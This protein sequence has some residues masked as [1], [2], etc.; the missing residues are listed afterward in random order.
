[1]GIYVRSTN[2]T[3]CPNV[4]IADVE[5][6]D[7]HKR[8][9]VA[10]AA[11]AGYPLGVAVRDCYIHDTD[12]IGI[13][14][15]RIDRISVLDNRLDAC[16]DTD[17]VECIWVSGDGVT[18]YNHNI[19]I[20]G[21]EIS[22]GGWSGVIVGWADH[23]TIAD[24][25]IRDCV[26]AGND[27]W[28]INITAYGSDFSITGNLCDGCGDGGIAVDLLRAGVDTTMHIARGTIT[29]NVCMNGLSNHGIYIARAQAL[30][31][32]GNTC[33]GNAFSG[34]S[35]N[36]SLRC[37]AIGNQVIN[38]GV[39][40]ISIYDGGTIANL[41]DHY[42]C[43]NVYQGNITGAYIDAQADIPSRNEDFAREV[44]TQS[45]NYTM[46]L[47]DETCIASGVGT[48]ITLLENAPV[49]KTYIVKRVDAANNIVVSREIADTID[50]AVSWSLNT[51]YAFVTCVSDGANYYII[52]Q[53]GTV[54]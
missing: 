43:G 52:A 8:G 28:G 34:I 16:G 48:T 17:D 45:S 44:T 50:G 40:G 51:D 25:N 20:R 9:V 29:G 31:I 42:L 7:S 6:K 47:M 5:I 54:V 3:G 26:K 10:Y 11:D 30:T 37:N 23:I 32:C 19:L 36:N 18:V 38:N 27:G 49:G 21:N 41:G 35:I 22:N 2:A 12:G 53:E 39:Y 33:E 15:T 46:T 14:A 4:T 24:N 1:M 13:Y